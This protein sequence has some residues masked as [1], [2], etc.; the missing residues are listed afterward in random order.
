[1]YSYASTTTATDTEM[2]RVIMAAV[3]GK[4]VDT[5]LTIADDC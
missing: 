4:C 1:M 3:E 5:L 2:L